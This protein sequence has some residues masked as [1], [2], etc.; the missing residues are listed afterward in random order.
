MTS[1]GASAT[2]LGA[3][4]E[5]VPVSFSWNTSNFNPDTHVIVEVFADRNLNRLVQARDVTGGTSTEI[6]LESDQYYWRVYPANSGSAEPANWMYPKGTLEVVPAVT[7]VP[8][9]PAREAEIIYFGE[10]RV[11]FSWSGVEGAAAYLVEISAHA[12]MSAP[13]VSRRVAEKSLTQAGL[14]S[15]LWYWRIT[16]LFPPWINGS[17]PPSTISEFTVTRGNPVLAAP[18]LTFPLDNGITY[19]DGDQKPAD[20]RLLWLY[21]SNAVSWLVELA[22]N[23][24]MINPSVKQ[25]VSFNEGLEHTVDWYLIHTE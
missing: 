14:E 7:A 5:A 2:I 13:A 11:A 24:A 18:V 22:D 15:G 10:S 3:P 23:P 17:V 4:E 9:A 8:L 16:P 6:P 25:N 21:D 20:N 19:L 1:F 12:D